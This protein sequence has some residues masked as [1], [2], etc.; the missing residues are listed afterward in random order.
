MNW[1]LFSMYAALILLGVGMVIYTKHQDKNKMKKLKTLVKEYNEAQSKANS[2]MQLVANRVVFCHFPEDDYDEPSIEEC[3]DGL[4]AI[5][6]GKEI[7]IEDVIE[8]MNTKGC[9]EPEDFIYG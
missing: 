6:K 3:S 8:L 1:S 7:F 5:W 2:A 9:I 4:I